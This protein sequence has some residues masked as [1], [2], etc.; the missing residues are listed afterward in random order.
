MQLSRHHHAEAASRPCKKH[1]CHQELC[2]INF[3]KKN[4]KRGQE[5]PKGAA[6]KGAEHHTR[7]LPGI[8]PALLAPVRERG[9]STGQG[10]GGA[11]PPA[12]GLVK[13]RR[14]LTLLRRETAST[15]AGERSGPGPP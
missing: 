10:N 14:G 3:G 15:G 5:R 7:V 8:S 2:P 13:E 12:A 4:Q 9:G 6:G 11:K 1:E